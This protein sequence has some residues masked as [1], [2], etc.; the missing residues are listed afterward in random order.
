[1]RKLAS[2][3]KITDVRDI[4]DADLIQ[5]YQV[6]GWWVVGKKGE[7]QI[8]DLVCY[9]EIDSWIPHEIAPFLS[10]GKEPR[11]FE[12]VKGE[13]LRTIKL[14]GQISQGLILPL[15]DTLMPESRIPDMSE[16]DDLTAELKIL[17]WEKPLHAQLRGRYKGYFPYLWRKTDQE[18]IQNLKKEFQYY[19]DNDTKFEVT[20]KLDGSSMSVGMHPKKENPEELEYTVCSRN[21]SIQTDDMDNAFV[22][23]AQ[24][25]NLEQICHDSMHDEMHFQ[26]SGE[27][28]GEGIQGNREKIQRTKF[29]IFDIWDIKEQKYIDPEKRQ[30]I[31]DFFNLDHVPVLHNNVS[32]KDLNLH[33]IDDVLAFAD[34]KSLNHPVREG[35]V[36]KSMDGKF[37]FKA[38]SNKFLLKEKD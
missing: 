14:K 30:L 22:K 9:F 20:V 11:E 8:D 36:F 23:T 6:D 10:K 19:Y 15:N 25:Y 5:A 18:R 7:F 13:R 1:M 28:M 34:G 12:G 33:S 4:P 17:K 3:R 16:G 31:A 35:V 37:S 24:N 21:L 26:I 32:L 29:Y 38:I 27:L 2:I